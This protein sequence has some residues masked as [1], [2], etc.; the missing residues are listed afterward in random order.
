MNI[1][2]YR[3][4]FLFVLT[5]MLLSSVTAQIDLDSTYKISELEEML[6]DAQVTKNK[7]NLAA[8]YYL[9][10]QFEAENFDNSANAFKNYTN[11]REYYNILKDSVN[12]TG[13]R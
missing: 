1:L 9:L 7:E 13:I 6:K 5:N 12:C 3:L 11:A 2:I 8:T 4:S 10:A